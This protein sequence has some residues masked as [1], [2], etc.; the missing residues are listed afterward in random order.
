ML[1][2]GIF[3]LTMIVIFLTFLGLVFMTEEE[4]RFYAD[5]HDY[6]G[7]PA[8]ILIPGEE[9]LSL[10]SFSEKVSM[11]LYFPGKEWDSSYVLFSG[12]ETTAA[13]AMTW[14][15]FF[16]DK[17]GFETVVVG[18][19]AYEALSASEQK[20]KLLS[21]NGRSYQIK[22]ILGNS[23]FDGQVLF[24]GQSQQVFETFLPYVT[25]GMFSAADQQDLA[26]F[27]QQNFGEKIN[28]GTM[29]IQSTNNPGVGDFTAN[30]KEFR[31]FYI[32]LA[33]FSVL[34]IMLQLYQRIEN[35]RLELSIRKL[36]GASPWQLVYDTFA[37]YFKSITISFLIS[38]TVFTGFLLV[39]F[40]FAYLPAAIYFP[41]IIKVS[42]LYV[43]IN[44][45]ALII[46]G[47]LTTR[48]SVNQLLQEVRE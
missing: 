41:T 24:N 47:W 15:T 12:N 27:I 48:K 37:K 26:D 14:G 38:L 7:S 35:W 33:I 20:E 32:Q 43:L 21:F 5:Y 10:D 16:S 18:K 11:L 6:Y 31:S 23:P 30:A 17:D 9:T 40:N 29:A 22:G 1:N 36:S 2:K 13:P 44:L 3:S 46:S 25:Q 19:T 45:S 4:R 28:A 34:S 8:T 39:K 42:L